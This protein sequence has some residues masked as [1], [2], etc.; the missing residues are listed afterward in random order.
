MSIQ[1]LDGKVLKSS[2]CS[3]EGIM[4]EYIMIK[5]MRLKTNR[6]ISRPQG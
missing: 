5:E 4:G 1:V 3:I 2:T 6:L